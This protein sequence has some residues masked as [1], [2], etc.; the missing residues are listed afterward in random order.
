MSPPDILAGPVTHG[1]PELQRIKYLCLFSTWP[2]PCKGP[3]PDRRTT[4]GNVVD[5]RLLEYVRL[6]S[7]VPRIW[8]RHQRRETSR[9][10]WIREAHGGG[11]NSRTRALLCG[12]AAPCTGSRQGSDRGPVGA[13]GEPRPPGAGGR[14][15]LHAGAQRCAAAQPDYFHAG[16]LRWPP[17]W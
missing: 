14:G 11:E 10:R 9:A 1:R 5:G 17:P 4:D 6:G 13:T 3:A 16:E 2:L 15:V 8:R 7:H 12:G